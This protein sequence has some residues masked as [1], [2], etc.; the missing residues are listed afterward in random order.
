M[1][2]FIFPISIITLFRCVVS[3]HIYLDELLMVNIFD[4]QKVQ[5][6]MEKKI[7]MDI[8]NVPIRLLSVK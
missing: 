6:E 5:D 8:R 7:F 4:I 2:N 3:R 1:L